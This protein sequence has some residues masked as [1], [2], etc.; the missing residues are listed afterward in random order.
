VFPPDQLDELARIF[1]AVALE[2][3]LNETAETSAHQE[4]HNQPPA[5][6]ADSTIIVIAG[7]RLADTARSDNISR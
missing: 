4:I 7:S 5:D 2:E 3:L 1:A 6:G